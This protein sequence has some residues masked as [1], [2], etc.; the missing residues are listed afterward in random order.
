MP[1]HQLTDSVVL[2]G[3]INCGGG[4]IDLTRF[5]NGTVSVNP[6][7]I[8]AVT[9]LAHTVTITGIGLV[10]GDMMVFEPPAALNDDLIY[11]GCRVTGDD[12]VDLY[13]YNPTGGAIDD[14]ARNWN[15][16]HFGLDT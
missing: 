1:K 16:L 6:A 14:T 4:N 13:I 12:T 2:V 3:G 15:Y 10:A 11:L 7:S 8:A 5:N 9:K